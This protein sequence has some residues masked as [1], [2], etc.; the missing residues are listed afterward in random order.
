MIAIEK[1]ININGFY[2]SDSLVQALQIPIVFLIALI[3][4]RSKQYIKQKYLTYI[5]LGFLCNLIYLSLFLNI[6]LNIILLTSNQSAN[7]ILLFDLLTFSFFYIASINFIFKNIRTR[8]TQN[9]IHDYHSKINRIK[10]FSLGFVSIIF[11]YLL[12]ANFSNN[13][14]QILNKISST[15]PNYGLVLYNSGACILAGYYLYKIIDVNEASHQFYGRFY[16][17]IGFV[18]WAIIQILAPW[19]KEPVVRF[20]GFF[21]STFAK[22]SIL[23]GYINYYI[24]LAKDEHLKKMSILSE[25]DEL[26][27][28]QFEFNRILK[29]TFHEIYIP[30]NSLHQSIEKLKEVIAREHRKKVEEIIS[31]F[32]RVCAIVQV[33]RDSYYSET[34]S[35]N[36]RISEIIIPNISK[37]LES[38]NL[39]S[40][41][42]IA[43]RSF[44]H[45]EAN[46]DF[47]LQLSS[48]CLIMCKSHEIVE[49]LINLIK[50][51]IEAYNKDG[52]CLVVI[53][54]IN[55]VL[56]SAENNYVMLELED[57]SSG[58]PT[59]ISEY[60][61]MEGFSTKFDKPTGEI[62]GQ[63]LFLVKKILEDPIYDLPNNEIN[64]QM[65]SPVY[66][67]ESATPFGTRFIL[68]FKKA[69]F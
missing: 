55:K 50:N 69:I 9:Y 42:E 32:E 60:I 17:L 37:Q 1:Y 22:I 38:V 64:I 21:I 59:N 24:N 49:I 47:E 68:T 11:L 15:L 3:S 14:N 25:R 16:I 66:G 56:G 33:S 23:Y 4:Y 20:I 53:R 43:I 26:V 18:I 54:T 8:S 10:N 12:F 45:R 28:S 31:V 57:N 61:W 30:L 35:F 34:S 46:V 29:H 58:I 2:E 44:K 62:K 13:D 5:S 27:K 63:G 51:S 65:T 6:N 39:N 52:K 7:L 19:I 48:K 40:L 41:I 36:K 67:L